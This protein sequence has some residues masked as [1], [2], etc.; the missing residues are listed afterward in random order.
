[1]SSACDGLAELRSGFVD[2]ALSPE[3]SERVVA[4]LLS[5]ADCRADVAEL[6]AV[7]DLLG[8]SGAGT[9][10]P[11]P[12]SAR[13]VSIADDASVRPWTKAFDGSRGLALPSERR[14]ARVRAV[15][16]TLAT[17]A[18]LGVVGL[19]GWFAAPNGNLA[20]VAD[21]ADEAQAEFG[22]AAAELSVTGASLSALMLLDSLP[23][24]TQDGSQVERPSQKIHH[25]EGEP[26]AVDL[27]DRA[28]AAGRTTTVAGDQAVLARMDERTV[29]ARVGVDTRSRQG[30]MVSVFD[31]DGHVLASSFAQAQVAAADGASPVDL[32]AHAYALSTGSGLHVAGRRA[33]VVEA[34]DEHGMV[35][36]RWWVDDATGVLLWQES[37]DDEGLSTAAGFTEVDVVPYANVAPTKAAT[38]LATSVVSADAAQLSRSGWSCSDEMAGLDLLEV[39]TDTP[40]DPRSVHVVYGDGAST[41]S[42]LQ[43]HGR[44]SGAPAGARWD[45]KL[46]AWRHSGAVRWATWQSG[47][48]VY[49]VTTD[50]PSSLLRRSVAAF[51][52]EGPVET[53][54]LGRVREGWSR[55]L[56]D[57]KG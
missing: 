30:A 23:E 40:T 2:G 24:A 51:P 44:L 25:A 3:D 4:H 55:I 57:L 29:A 13:L 10:A 17:G 27:L 54:T 37:Y 20:A 9:P 39:T 32:I 56:A 8:R 18:I 41:V 45:D 12:L 47:D 36:K 11:A 50:G 53:T 5:C 21:P 15:L 26:E 52:H 28:M 34:R 1:M 19:T 22:A 35:A 31:P 33:S 46:Q 42:V 43:R 48:T 6:R 7:R 38:R 49:T 16:G 14:R